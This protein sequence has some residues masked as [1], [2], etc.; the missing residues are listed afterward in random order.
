MTEEQINA[1]AVMRH[2]GNSN[3]EIAQTLNM[4]YDQVGTAVFKARQRN[5]LPPKPK[6]NPRQAVL[7]LVKG[8]GL[9]QGRISDMMIELSKPERV[10]VIG[11]AQRDG[12]ETL[13]EWLTDLV[14]AEYDKANEHG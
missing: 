12:Y 9:R 4:T 14:R 11:Q 13:A 6:A 3:R 7:D 1:V 10:W 5:I 8:N 2:A